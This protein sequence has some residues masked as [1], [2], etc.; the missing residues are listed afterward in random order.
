MEDLSPKGRCGK[1]LGC[2]PFWAWTYFKKQAVLRVGSKQRLEMFLVT[3]S[4]AKDPPLNLTKFGLISTHQ[5]EGW[6]ETR[7]LTFGSKHLVLGKFSGKPEEQTAR[8]SFG[9]QFGLFPAAEVQSN[10]TQPQQW[11]FPFLPVRQH[12]YPLTC[13]T[14]ALNSFLPWPL[15]YNCGGGG[16]AF[17]GTPWAPEISSAQRAEIATVRLWSGDVRDRPS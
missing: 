15:G 16:G 11:Q 13:R 4:I 7:Y 14:S 5:P 9:T 10:R 6:G 1:C 17:Q 3:Q 2:G 12:P 8:A